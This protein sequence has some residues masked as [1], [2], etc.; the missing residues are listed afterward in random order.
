MERENGNTVLLTVIGIAT[1]LVALVGATFAY[2][3]ATVSDESNQSVVIT[4]ASVASLTFTGSNSFALTNVVP[5]TAATDSAVFT[6]ANPGGTNTITYRYDLALVVDGNNFIGSTISGGKTV[7]TNDNTQEA[8]DELILTIAPIAS[9]ASGESTTSSAGVTFVN[10]TLGTTS[11]TTTF[12]DNMENVTTYPQSTNKHIIYSGQNIAA[13]NTIAYKMTVSFNDLNKGDN[14][15]Q[16]K[17]FSGHVEATNIQ[18]V[19]A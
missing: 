11:G 13:G 9:G 8:G 14:T 3:T 15:N 6:I 10:T 16:G 5:G 4:T 19:G 17:S 1:L 12:T 7:R 18:S 2:F